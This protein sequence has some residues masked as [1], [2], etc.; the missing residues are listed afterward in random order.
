[1]GRLV[2]SSQGFTLYDA[3]HLTWLGAFI[4]AG[5]MICF[6]Y[7]RM[8]EKQKRIAE[9]ITGVLILALEAAKY[10]RLI[11]IGEELIYYL[12]LHLCSFAIYIEFID[13][14]FSA[15][16]TREL[17]YSI[18]LPA[19]A[20]ALLFPGWTDE[21]VFSFESFHSFVIHFLLA[22]YPVLLLTGRKL[23]PE[24]KRLPVCFA[25]TALAAAGVYL[26]DRRLGLNYMFLLKPPPGSPLEWFEKLFGNP[27]YLLGYVIIAFVLWA[28]MYAPFIIHRKK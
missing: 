28:L 25:V 15:R 8:N 7:R 21:P 6:I 12:P 5:V 11:C 17:T 18:C 19:A 24:I 23:R 2:S 22:L 16:L 1:M 14:L 20:A 26:I 9:I 13:S 4:A 3:V 10:I 27:G